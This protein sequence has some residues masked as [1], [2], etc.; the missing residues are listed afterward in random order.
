MIVLFIFEVLATHL[1]VVIPVVVR[2]AGLVATGFMEDVFVRVPF[3]RIGG[4]KP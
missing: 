2:A 4:H 1:A 3:K